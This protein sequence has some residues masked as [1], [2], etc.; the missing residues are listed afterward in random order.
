MGKP[1]E[2]GDFIWKDPPFFMGKLTKSMAMF[3]SKLLVYQRV[4]RIY[5][6]EGFHL[7]LMGCTE[8]RV[9]IERGREREREMYIMSDPD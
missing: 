1:W 2:N 7:D 8:I 3:N 4:M 9:D 5:K 6:G